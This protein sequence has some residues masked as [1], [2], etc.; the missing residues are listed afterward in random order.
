[1]VL[2]KGDRAPS[3]ELCDQDGKPVRL[4]DFE[5]KRLLLYFYAKAGTPG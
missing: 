4:A 3:F 5:G 1:M 2:R